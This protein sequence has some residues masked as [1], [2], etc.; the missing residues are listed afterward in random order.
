MEFL[1]GV[2]QWYMEGK[3]GMHL[4]LITMIFSFSI[5]IERVW[6]VVIKSNI[7]AEPF[8]LECIKRIK[9]RDINGAIELCNKQDTPLT[10]IIKGALQAFMEGEENIQQV[11][12]EISLVEIPRLD[13]R[14]PYLGML[15]NVAVLLGLLGTISGLITC[16]GSLAGVSAAEKTTILSAGISEA[17]HCTAF[18]LFVAITS[19]IFHGFLVG[20]S[21]KIMADID[22]SVVKILNTLE[23][24]RR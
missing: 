18:G 10:R 22:S 17:M 11:T 3:W 9:K 15:A 13:R 4:I 14:I 5:I 8:T 20:R 6:Y 12:D 21:T 2:A 1:Q 7:K 16:F 19:V 23:E 24:V